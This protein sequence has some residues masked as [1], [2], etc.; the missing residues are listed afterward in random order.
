MTQFGQSGSR[1]PSLIAELIQGHD[2]T[3][4]S[5]KDALREILSGEASDAQIAGFLVGLSAKGETT[6]EIVGLR[7]AMLDVA[8]GLD[9]P[10]STIDIVGVGGSTQ[11]HQSAFNIS[12]IAA[13]VA[14]AAGASVCKHGNRK[15]SSTSGSFDLLEALGLNINCSPATV[16]SGVRSFGLGFAFARLHH[17]AMR[18]VGPARSQIGVPTVFNVLGPLAHP[19]RVKRQVIGVPDHARAAQIADVLVGS[20]SELVWIVTGQ[21]GLDEISLSGPT[22]VIS[23]SRGTRRHF[24]VEPAQVGLARVK[25]GSIEGG[26]AQANALLALSVLNAERSPHRDVVV[27]NAAAGLVVAGVTDDLRTGTEMAEL[28]IDDGTARAKLDT[29]IAHSQQVDTSEL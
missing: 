18:F 19:G 7:S 15:A 11:R 5:S 20:D 12:T 9:L 1:W 6:E 4:S 16:A 23:V 13:I 14:S 26:D 29:V 3:A 22:Q 24:C 28:A 17:P 27:L 8:V 2:L 10:A 21:G 25:E